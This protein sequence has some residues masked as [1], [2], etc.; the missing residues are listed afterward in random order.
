MFHIPLSCDILGDLRKEYI[1][2]C[3]YVYMKGNWMK[4]VLHTNIHLKKPA[5]TLNKRLGSQNHQHKLPQNS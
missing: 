3:M 4:P 1:Y 5:G 2:V